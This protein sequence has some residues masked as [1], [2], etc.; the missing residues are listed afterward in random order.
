ISNC[1]STNRWLMN[2]NMI[3]QYLL[4][5]LTEDAILTR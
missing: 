1:Q 5:S 4:Q 2:I 3:F